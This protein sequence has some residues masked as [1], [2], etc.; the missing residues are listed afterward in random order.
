MVPV[1]AL[2]SVEFA[3]P[4]PKEGSMYTKS[5]NNRSLWNFHLSESIIMFSN[6]AK[7]DSCVVEVVVLGPSRLGAEKIDFS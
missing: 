7:L 2:F 5:K 4:K 3:C 6:K 1:S